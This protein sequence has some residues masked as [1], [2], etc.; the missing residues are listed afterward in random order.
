[1]II[2]VRRG[3]EAN[4]TSYT[5]Q[6]GE[7]TFTTD[8]KELY[9]GDGVTPGGILVDMSGAGIVQTIV[10]GTNIT[11]DATDPLNPIVSAAGG[12]GGGSGDMEASTYDPTTVA[13]D[14]FDMDNM[15]EGTDTKILTGAERTTIGNQSGT[16]TG[17]QT[18]PTALT[19]LDTTV[20][21]TQLNTLQSNTSG[22]NTGDQDIADFETT[23]ELNARDTANRDRTNHTGT[24]T[25]STISDFDTEVSNNADVT[26]NTTKV[27]YTD[28]AKVAGIETAAT[29]NPDAVDGSV[30]STD[31]AIARYDGTTGKLVQDSGVTIDDSDNVGSDGI[32]ESSTI[33]GAPLG[34]FDEIVEY[35]LDAGVNIEG[36]VHKDGLIDGRDVAADGIQVDSAVQPGDLSTVATTGAYGDLSGS[37]TVPTTVDDLNPSQTGNSGKFLKTDGINAVWESIPG[38]GDMLIATY[39]PTAIGADAFARANHTGTQTAS[40]VSDFDTE[41]SNNTDVT[42]NTAKV[43]YTDSAKVAGI[44]AGADVTDTTNVT[45]AGAH[46]SGGTDV[47]ITDGGTGSS[48]ASGA[49][50][51][52]G[53]TDA[54][55]KNT[56][57]TKANVGLGNVDNTSNATERAASATLTNK[58]ISSS[59]NTFPKFVEIGSFTCPASTGDRAVTGV[60]FVPRVIEFHVGVPSNTTRLGFNEGAMNSSTQWVNSTSG[61]SGTV[62]RNRDTTHCLGWTNIDGS[63]YI[64]ASYVSLDSDGFTVNFNAVNTLGTIFWKAFR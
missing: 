62:S 23:T 7:P 58:T 14:A 18:L 38:G 53:V 47:P 45:S 61:S 31:N 51:N 1:M 30:S 56:N 20:T 34:S 54:N 27:S 28:A 21:G 46:M 22:T 63:W 42:A 37:P 57:T 55:Y 41:V 40:T 26:T 16:N 60:G 8:T 49:R 33:M 29:A 52:L 64:Q 32:I 11:I 35:F 3:L 10:A 12:G 5:P 2:R 39:D 36:V 17:D 24:Q 50:T 25:A 44:E 59:T 6:V 4:R 48:T 15:V 43:S 9:I 13:G 19:D